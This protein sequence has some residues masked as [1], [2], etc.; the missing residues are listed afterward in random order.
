MFQYG[1]GSSLLPISFYKNFVIRSEGIGLKSGNISATKYC[2]V[3]KFHHNRLVPKTNALSELVRIQCLLYWCRQ[4]ILRSYTIPSFK[5]GFV[6][7]GF[8]YPL[9]YGLVFRVRRLNVPTSYKLLLYWWSH[10]LFV[11]LVCTIHTLPGS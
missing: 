10:S 5:Y 2:F 3:S 9:L 7:L 8:G 6:V 11:L 4:T 1:R